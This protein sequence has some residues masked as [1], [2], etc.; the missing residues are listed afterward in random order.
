MSRRHPRVIVLLSLLLLA[1]L[2]AGGYA[3]YLV[4]QKNRWAQT[5]LSET[6]PRHA[7]LMGLDAARAELDSALT[8][9]QT[10]RAQLVYPATQDTNQT[11]NAA[12]QRVRDIL[13]A[14]GL[15]VLSSQVLPPASGK[16]TQW[17]RITLVVR[18]EGDAL[19]LYNALATLAAQVPVVV[20]NELDVQVQSQLPNAPPRLSMQF[21]LVVLREPA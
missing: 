12:Q 21:N 14:S 18:T 10:L 1:I 5:V 4:W 9:A 15:Q 20:I 3:A 16:D 17:D 6:A 19:A 8:H 2:T 7:R 11:G 13:S